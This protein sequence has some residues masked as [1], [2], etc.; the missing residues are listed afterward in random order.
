MDELD[1]GGS[2]HIF[3]L[4]RLTESEFGRDQENK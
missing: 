4:N 1:P 3:E 2:R